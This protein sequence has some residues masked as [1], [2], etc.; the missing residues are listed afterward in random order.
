MPPLAQ[1]KRSKS[2]QRFG[3][4]PRM[5]KAISQPIKKGADLTDAFSPD[6]SRSHR[7]TSANNSSIIHIDGAHAT[8]CEANSFSSALHHLDQRHSIFFVWM[9]CAW[10]QICIHEQCKDGQSGHEM[11]RE[12][13][14]M[15]I[16]ALNS[17]FNMTARRYWTL[18][19][20]TFSHFT[21]QNLLVNMLGLAIFA[22]AF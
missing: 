11:C 18:V 2:S 20:S 15:M 12:V 22:R 16:N 7:S 6:T 14:W 8:T 9:R 19:T 5:P 10:Q 17:E 1:V 4:Q 21:P 13:Q 3:G